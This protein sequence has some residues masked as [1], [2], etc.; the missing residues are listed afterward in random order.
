MERILCTAYGD[1]DANKGIAVITENGLSYSLDYLKIPGKCNFCIEYEDVLYVPVK[2]G[3]NLIM[4]F[5]KQGDSFVLDGTYEVGYFY[6]HGTVF[7]DR[8]FLASFFRR[9]RCDL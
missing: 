8:L 5:R 3:K 9:C 1:C 4:E 2:N 6:S 7:H